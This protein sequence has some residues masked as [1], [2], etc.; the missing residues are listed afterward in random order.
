MFCGENMVLS[1][2]EE[3]VDHMKVCPALQEQ[4]TSTDQFTIPKSIQSKME[5]K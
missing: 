3:A 5:R 1:N 4:L 2:E